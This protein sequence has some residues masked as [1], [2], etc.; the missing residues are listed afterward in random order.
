MILRSYFIF[1]ILEFIFLIMNILDACTTYLVVTNSSLRSE[2][3]PLARFF[4]K[5]LGLLK[6]ILLLKSCSI[7]LIIFMF[8]CYKL[9]KSDIN[10]IL[11]IANFVYLII[12]LNNYH[13]YRKIKK[14]MEIN[15]FSI[16]S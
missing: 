12:V 7:L 5:K 6:G 16:N 10:L 9:I 1:L 2:K 4:F 13:S 15:Q 3:N 11:I 14:R 8:I